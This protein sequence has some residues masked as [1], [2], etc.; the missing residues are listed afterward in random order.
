MRLPPDVDERLER[1]RADRLTGE[2]VLLLKDGLILGWRVT[3]H[4]R[5]VNREP[6]IPR[7]D[8]Q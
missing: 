1:A 5:V 2:V 8:L 6:R 4:G 3:E 7:L